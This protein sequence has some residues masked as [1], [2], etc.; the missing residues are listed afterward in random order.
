MTATLLE[1]VE[2]V[3]RDRLRGELVIACIAQ[4]DRCASR[5]QVELVARVV[6]ELVKPAKP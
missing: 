6:A 3:A 1:I 4:L 2:T 5:S